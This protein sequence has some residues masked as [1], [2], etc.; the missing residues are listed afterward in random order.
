M[1]YTHIS[2]GK[3]KFQTHIAEDKIDNIASFY[4]DK[5]K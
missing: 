2:E 1:F 4:N 3:K 5:Q